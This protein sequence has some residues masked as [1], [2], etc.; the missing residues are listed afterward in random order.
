MSIYI[1]SKIDAGVLLADSEGKLN[2]IRVLDTAG[3]PVECSMFREQL[4]KNGSYRYWFDASAL[5]RWTPDTPVLYMLEADDEKIRFGFM[6]LRPDGNRALLLKGSP[7][8]MR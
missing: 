3:S 1:R 4:L 6:E 7:V 5:T 2:R 8:Y